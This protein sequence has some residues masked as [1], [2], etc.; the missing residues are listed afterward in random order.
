MK[1]KYEYLIV[2]FIGA[3]GYL[4]M[5][6]LFR[7][8]SHWTMFLMGGMCFILI[9]LISNYKKLTMPEK[10]IIG[11]ITIT[12]AE[13]F[14]GGLFNLTLRWGVWTYSKYTMNILGQI[15]PLFS[16]LW[17]LLCIPVCPLCIKLKAAFYKKEC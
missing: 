1:V 3:I 11:A 5:E 10:W 2:F 7:G 15:C 17:I 16:F 4:I 9:Y 12:A 14:A 13:F 6:L 8:H